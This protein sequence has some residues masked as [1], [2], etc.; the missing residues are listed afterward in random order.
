MSPVRAH[1]RRGIFVIVEV[2][3]FLCIKICRKY[4]YQ[5]IKNNIFFLFQYEFV[6][7]AIS[8]Y[9]DLYMN[10]DEEYEYSVPVGHHL[11]TGTAKVNIL[12]YY[13]H[14]L[15]RVLLF[16]MLNVRRWWLIVISRINGFPRI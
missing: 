14:F 11:N 7:R 12:F 16:L 8:D 2:S 9:V 3:K 5:I 13:I 15:N 10:K 1:P 6:Y 4:S